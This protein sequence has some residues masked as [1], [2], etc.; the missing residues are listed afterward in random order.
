[1]I[2]KERTRW[3]KV[4]KKDLYL[5]SNSKVDGKGGEEPS[6]NEQEKRLTEK[7]AGRK[8]LTKIWMRKGKEP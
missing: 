6:T 1:M 5:E 3:K 8:K 4:Q 2:K 7:D